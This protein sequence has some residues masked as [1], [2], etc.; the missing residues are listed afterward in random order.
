MSPTR[1]R[2]YWSFVFWTG[3]ALLLAVAVAYHAKGF[4]LLFGEGGGDDLHQ[5]WIETRYVAK[6]QNPYDVYY[7][8]FTKGAKPW[9]EARDGRVD[10]A[11]GY[12]DDGGYPPWAFISGWL[13]L[14]PSWPSALSYYA[15]LSLAAVAVVGCWAATLAPQGAGWAGKAYLFAAAVALSAYG[16]T[17]QVGQYGTIVVAFIAACLWLLSLRRGRLGDVLA[18]LL[19]GVAMLKPT[20]AGPFFLVLLFKRRWIAAAACVLYVSAAAGVVWL[21]T[22]TNPVEMCLQMTASASDYVAD[23]QGLVG[24]LLSLGLSRK[25]VTPVLAVG[26]L[27]PAIVLLW[28]FRRRSLPTLFAIAAVA[29]R[30]WSYHKGYDNG[31]MVFLLA[32]LLAAWLREPRNLLIGAGALLVGASLW[33]P[34]GLTHYPPILIA[35]L[36]IW[37]VG[38]GILLFACKEAASPAV[39]AP[40]AAPPASELAH[41]AY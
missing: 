20:I 12:P 8:S 9:S 14:W 41:S 27:L 16:T 15:F 34:A 37:P 3:A 2:T 26:V 10:E 33:M 21:W 39:E 1:L 25:L 22:A 5:R 13:F 11:I 19:L 29:A 28:T 6:G 38:L 30:F 24:P 32:P 7:Y 31:M 18:G 40:A 23:S 36:L 4:K 17:L 35:Q